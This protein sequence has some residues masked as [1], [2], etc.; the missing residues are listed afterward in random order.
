M[1][2]VHVFGKGQEVRDVPVADLSEACGEP[3]TL[4]WVDLVS[5]TPEELAA[6]ISGIDRMNFQHIPE[7]GWRFGYAWALALMVVSA[8]GLWVYFKRKDWL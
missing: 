3:R 6:M 4:V 5:A 7:L 8:T 2:Q 1:I